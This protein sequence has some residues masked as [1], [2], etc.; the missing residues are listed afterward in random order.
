MH[1]DTFH[2]YFSLEDHTVG[3]SKMKYSLLGVFWRG[4]YFVRECRRI[5]N[6]FYKISVKIICVEGY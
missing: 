2:N 1:T 5:K 6:C 4:E 3:L